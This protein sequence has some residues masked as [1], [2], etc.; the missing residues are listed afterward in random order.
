[1][2]LEPCRAVALRRS[3]DTKCLW[4]HRYYPKKR[5][6]NGATTSTSLCLP[7]YDPRLKL[8]RLLPELVFLWLQIRIRGLF[9]KAIFDQ[10][11]AERP[12]A[13]SEQLGGLRLNAIRFSQR[14]PDHA[15]LEPL[16]G[17]RQVSFSLVLYFRVLCD[18]RQIFNSNDIVPGENH[19]ALDNVFQLPHISRIIVAQQNLSAFVRHA[20]NRLG[21]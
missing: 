19:G 14:I 16:H 21:V 9:A 1:M 11:I 5:R 13:D 12:F 18:Q 10:F 17:N 15:A 4:P 7:A 8:R 6:A 20:L 2:I 3:A